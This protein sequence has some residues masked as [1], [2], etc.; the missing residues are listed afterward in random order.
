MTLKSLASRLHLALGVSLTVLIV[1]AW[2]LGHYAL[3]RSAEAYVLHRLQHDA[4]ALL[5][6]IAVD[7][8]SLGGG[9]M[10]IYSQPF[11]GHYFALRWAGGNVERSRSLWSHG[12]PLP[13]LAPGE[14]A[15]MQIDGPDGQQLLVRAAGYQLRQRQLVLAVAEDLLPMEAFLQRFERWFAVLAIVGLAAII[16]VARWIVHRAFRALNPVYRDID[17]LEHGTTDRLSDDVPTEIR[18]LVDK[19]NGLLAVYDKRLQRSR[20]AAGNLAHALKGPLMLMLRQLEQKAGPL[21]AD[22]RAV[23]RQQVERVRDLVERELKRARIAGGGTAGSLFEPAEEL[24]VLRDLLLQ[25]YG[26]KALRIDCRLDHAGALAADR[27]DMLELFGT[28]LDNACKWAAGRVRCAIDRT[29]AGI[30]ACIEDDGP[31][32]SDAELAGLGQR[33]NRLDE[34]IAGHGLGLSIAREIVEQ[35]GGTLDVGRSETLGGFAAI[36][37]LPLQQTGPANLN[38]AVG[39]RQRP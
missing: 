18:P 33:G 16:G 5:G 20:N 17:A 19:L 21:A 35:Y 31:G 38:P 3:H 8:A 7:P 24:P 2:W 23:C 36:V 4:E 13:A 11:S 34:G 10:P 9:A 1:L 30:R 37:V 29:D 26:D 32:C 25:M 28:L 27:E 14:V 6:V 39:T 15:T 22:S 12:L